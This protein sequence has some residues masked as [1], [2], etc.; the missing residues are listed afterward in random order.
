MNSHTW[1]HDNKL[2]PQGICI[3]N[4]DDVRINGAVISSLLN[5]VSN[6]WN[7]RR[8]DSDRAILSYVSDYIYV[9]PAPSNLARGS[10]GVHQ[11]VAV[12]FVK[13]EP[14]TPG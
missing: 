9:P 5:V 11:V 10:C 6:V 2:E 4:T 14:K 3:L 7:V 13:T 1:S 8:I 12:V